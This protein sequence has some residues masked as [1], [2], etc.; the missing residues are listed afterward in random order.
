MRGALLLLLP[1]VVALAGCV[2]YESPSTALPRT[3]YEKH[4]ALAAAGHAE[5]QNLVGVMLFFG[6]GVARNRLRAYTWFRS[7]A[8]QGHAGAQRNLAVMHHLGD[9]VPE[10]RRE[11]ARLFRLAGH[12]EWPTVAQLVQ[13]AR[14]K[15]APKPGETSYVTFCAGCHGLNGVS[16]Y[17]HS[18]SFAVGERMEKTDAA[19][20]DSVANGIGAMPGWGTKLPRTVLA[21]IVS[22]IRSFPAQYRLGV[23]HVP[24]DAPGMFFLFGAMRD[25]DLAY[26]PRQ[27]DELTEE[28]ERP[29]PPGP[30]PALDG[31]LVPS[32]VT[33]ARR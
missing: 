22:F 30:S 15:A 16:A 10:N 24:R 27:D 4:R 29:R 14:T 26:R 8:D 7:A 13:H 3:T 21:E 1:V 17:V 2:R 11:A 18:P 19:L 25:N 9:S 6:E 5:S 32:A 31:D 28:F 23:A 12:T 33:P 20:L